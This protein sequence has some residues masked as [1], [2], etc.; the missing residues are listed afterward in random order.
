MRSTRLACCLVLLTPACGDSGSDSDSASGTQTGGGPGGSLTDPTS[1]P[2][3]GATE[4]GGTGTGTG[5]ASDSAT[6]TPTTGDTTV[7]VTGG[8]TGTTGG[9]TGTG[10]ASTTG[11][12]GETTMGSDTADTTGGGGFFCS[13][14]DVPVG[15]V[16]LNE[17]CDVPLQMGS[18]TPVVEWKWGTG[19]F[20][21]PAVAGQTIDSNG[22]G[23]IDAKDLPVVFL[24]QS[25]PV[26]ALW[27]DGSGVAWQSPGNYG[28]DGGMALG[29]IDGDGWSEL[30]TAN[31]STVCALDARDGT[32]KWCTAG[33]NANLDPVG[34]SYPEIADMDGDGL[35]EV[36]V[37]SAILDSA[38]AVIGKGMIGKGA[39]PY[40]GMM[41]GNTY[42][43]VSAV[44]DLDGDGVQ[45]V[46][47]GNAAYDL[48]GNVIWQ[49]GG[50]DGLVAVADFDLDGKGEIVKT[51]GIHVFGMESDGTVVWGPVTYGGN[52]GVPA[53]D[54]LD[55]DGVP[56]IVLGAQNNLVALAWG[57]AEKWKA[58]IADN[59][60]AAG[61]VLFDFEMDGYP[62]VLYADEKTI[63]FFSGIDGKPKFTSMEHASYTI[64]E[65][66]I[67]ADVDGDDQVEIVL[68][69]CN[70]NA[71]IG[72]ITVYGDKDKTWPPG[73]K[74]WNQHTYHVT[75]ITDL[76]GVPDQYQSNW[77]GKDNFNS[78][79]SG[80]V[81]QKPGE[82]HDLQVEILGVCEEEC[83]MGTFAMAAR[84][85][86]AGNLE[87]PAGIP[88][89]VR[90]GIG[91]KIAVTLET[92]QAIPPGKTGE[93]LFF[94]FEAKALAQSQ[95]VITVDDTGVGEGKIFECD[96][97]N[98]TA[99]WPLEVCP[100]VRPG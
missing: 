13:A 46:V 60:G 48:D 32:Q 12:T 31:G 41:G 92:T 85:R 71:Q 67:V 90:A 45:E 55:G 75:N 51:S 27:G 29:D 42:G 33:L 52:L 44:V 10:T 49:N 26:V 47:T 11:E 6:S 14:P 30:I 87:V 40:G 74:I 61:P 18:F 66:P 36:I 53:I 77:I 35:A 9:T 97:S 50:L 98:N 93:I 63:R 82:Y 2:T 3:S 72:A 8:M 17:S 4:S 58:P 34:Y 84:P 64:L 88:V 43:A 39:A 7:D 54:D 38:G 21:G 78:F 89:T 20:C 56:E 100:T 22:S 59:S 28:K 86:N 94:E 19:T 5:S 79:R 15:D 23:Q 62:E 65:T 99:V 96:E 68:G 70:A 83:E 69:H 16:A 95:P 1:E 25:G 24:Y 57:G 37:G 73:R 81:G 76:G 91:G 80:D